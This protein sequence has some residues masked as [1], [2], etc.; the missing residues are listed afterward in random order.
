MDKLKASKG[1]IKPLGR[2]KKRFSLALRSNPAQSKNF[3]EAMAG[4]K[5]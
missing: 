5:L 4:A 1:R 2:S 3:A